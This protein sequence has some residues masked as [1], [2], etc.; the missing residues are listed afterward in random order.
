[1]MLSKKETFEGKVNIE[2]YLTDKN[3]GDLFLDFQ[4]AAVSELTVNGTMI[5]DQAI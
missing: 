2:F 5:A 3:I 4:G 1:M